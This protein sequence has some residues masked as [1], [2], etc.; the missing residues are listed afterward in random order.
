MAKKVKITYR[1]WPGHFCCSMNCV[2][3]LNTL[4]EYGNKRVV[5]STVGQMYKDVNDREKGYDTIG[6]GRFYETMAF[7]ACKEKTPNGEF[8]DAD[9]SK[10]VSF[11][12]K[13]CWEKLED[14]LNAQNGHEKVVREIAKKLE[15][16][17]L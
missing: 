12:S 13:W 1:G 3:R 10:Q 6:C 9:V 14:E 4:I 17:K 7:W 11:S 15:K 2:F 8:W 5:V 16:G